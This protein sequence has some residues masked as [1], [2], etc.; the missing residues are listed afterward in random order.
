MH[1]RP[2]PARRTG[3]YQVEVESRGDGGQRAG[4]HATQRS[5]EHPKNMEINPRPAPGST[6]TPFDPPGS[7]R[8]DERSLLLGLCCA[9]GTARTLSSAR[10]RIPIG[11]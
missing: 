5:A 4:A 10:S 9:R 6:A 8:Q 11:G 2:T 3:E 1:K 7:F